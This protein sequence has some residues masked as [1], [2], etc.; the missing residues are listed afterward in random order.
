MNQ[1]AL[2][3]VQQKLLAILEAKRVKVTSKVTPEVH[4]YEWNFM[5]ANWM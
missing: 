1:L 3:N 5:L 4:Q 2:K